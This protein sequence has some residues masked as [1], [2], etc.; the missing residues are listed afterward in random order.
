M[1]EQS[2]YPSLATIEQLERRLKRPLAGAE[3]AAAAD[4]LEEASSAVRRLTRQWLSFVADDTEVRDGPGGVLLLLRQA[5]IVDLTSIEIGGRTLA[6]HDVMPDPETGALWRLGARWPFGRQSIRVT[7]SHGLRDIPPDLRGLVLGM[8]ERG[9]S[10]GGQGGVRSETIGG[11]RYDLG[12]SAGTGSLG[13][14]EQEEATVAHYRRRYRQVVAAGR[15]L[16]LA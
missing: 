5:P 7:Y 2:S 8:A 11:Y 12:D 15:A 9:L 10:Q 1:A 4:A 3:R 13:L 14:T 16:V 6:P